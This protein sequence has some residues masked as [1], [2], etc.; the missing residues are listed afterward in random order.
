MGS[1]LF[2]ST[3]VSG[4]WHHCVYRYRERLKRQVEF[5][6]GSLLFLSSLSVH[7]KKLDEKHSTGNV[8]QQ[9]L[10]LY[11][12]F[13]LVSGYA[14]ALCVGVSVLRAQPAMPLYLFLA[15]GSH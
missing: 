15:H 10:S 14:H 1:L 5:Q 9:A 11:P 12:G 7:F 3:Y 6:Q 8:T 4:F 2:D 13:R